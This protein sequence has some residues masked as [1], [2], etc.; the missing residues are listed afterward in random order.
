MI[1]TYTRMQTQAPTRTRIIR[2]STQSPSDTGTR[3]TASRRIHE[4][5]P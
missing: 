4:R 5:T 1:T 3:I 2:S